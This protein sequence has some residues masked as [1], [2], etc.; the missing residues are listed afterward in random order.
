M[1]KLFMESFRDTSTVVWKSTFVPSEI[2]YAI[3]GVPLYIETFSAMAAGVGMCTDML[4]ASE[5]QG[6]SRDCCS[7]LRGVLGASRKDILP[8]PDALISSSYYCD[9]DPMIFDIFADE[10]KSLHHYLHIPFF[11][12]GEDACDLVADQLEEITL[13]Q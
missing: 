2:I 7:F 5:N 12:E 6:F 9:G 3:G 4:T 13:V 11:S 1:Y 8:K 10:Y